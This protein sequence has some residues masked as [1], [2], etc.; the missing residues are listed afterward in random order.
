MQLDGPGLMRTVNAYADSAPK[1][2][3]FVFVLAFG[4]GHS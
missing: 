4:F 3:Q 1:A 2:R